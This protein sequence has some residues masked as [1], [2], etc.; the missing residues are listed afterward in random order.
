MADVEIPEDLR[1]L[2]DFP[3][4]DTTFQDGPRFRQNLSQWALKTEK[5]RIWTG[6]RVVGR[7]SSCPERPPWCGWTPFLAGHV[8]GIESG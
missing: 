1:H 3:T 7:R 4:Y 6:G 2:E 8:Y 5:V